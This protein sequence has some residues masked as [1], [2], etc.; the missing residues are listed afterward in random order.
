[1]K[2]HL[3]I[4]LGSGMGGGLRYGIDLLTRSMGMG[5]FPFSTFF[6]NLSGAFL[7]GYLAGRWAKD[8]RMVVHPQKWNLWVTGFCGGYTTFSAFSWQVLEL[9]QSGGG[10]LAGAYAAA[11]IGL[12]VFA[13]S[14]GIFYAR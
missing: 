13:V 6:I 1:M 7:V 3:Y 5:G 8:G 9:V 12:G 2:T 14:I 11:S 4:A 10:T